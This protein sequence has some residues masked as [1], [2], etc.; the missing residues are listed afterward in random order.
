MSG[1]FKDGKQIESKPKAPK[2]KTAQESVH[3]QTIA[4]LRHK[5]YL[6]HENIVD[7]FLNPETREVMVLERVKKLAK[8]N[9]S[10]L[11]LRL[12]KTELHLEVTQFL[13]DETHKA[14]QFLENEYLKSG[15]KRLMQAANKTAG[16]AKVHEKYTHV[17]E[18]ARQILGV[19]TEKDFKVFC[20]KMRA[21]LPSMKLPPSSLRNYYLEIT[22][23]KSTKN[24]QH[25]CDVRD[26]SIPNS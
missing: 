24:S 3:E 10:E 5:S 1:Q 12:A 20:K 25:L 15:K 22:G 11:L 8:L 26:R 6:F 9:P 16:K 13:Y 2:R 21:K 23:L 7:A 4:L 17:K 18:T 19:M 14:K